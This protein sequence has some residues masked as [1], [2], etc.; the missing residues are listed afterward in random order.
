M[1][2]QSLNHLFVSLTEEKS[3]SQAHRA[4]YVVDELDY[5][6]RQTYE[7]LI[8]ATDS[9]SG[10]S[11]EV[12]VSVLV[13][14]V[15]DC[16]PEIEQDSY[17][18]TVS[19]R[20]P[21]GTAI[22][23]VQAKD[24]D[25]G[26][27]QV[28]NYALQTDSKNTSEHFHMDPADGVI[29]LK[30]SLDHET[31]S[32]HHF[33][34]VASDKGVPSLSSTAHVWVSVM[35]MNDNPPKFEQPSYSCVLSEHASRGQFVTVVSASDPDYIDH[36]RL[37]YTIAQGNELQTYG[38]DPV[39]GIITL[40]NM[41]NF[42]EKHVSILNV[43]VTDGVYT[44]F[45][46]VKITILPANLHNPVFEHMFYDAKVDENQLAGR[47]VTT[48]KA[49]DKDFGE[50]GRLAYSI[51]SDD[52]QDYFSIDKEKG[53]IV[54]K[55]KLDREERMHYDI[56]VMAVDAGGRAGF[57]TVRLRVGDENDNQPVF[58]YREYKTLIQGNLT[59]N[60]TFYRV[61]AV[62]ADDNQN[63]VVKYS[64]FDS[65]NSG[66]RELFGV[67]EN[68]GGLYLQ[69]SAVQWENQ[70]FQF[71]I[72]AHD[73]GTP[74]LYS[75]VPIDIYIMSSAENPPLFEKK[76]RKLFLSESSLPGTV[77]TRLKLSGNVTARYRILS[78]ELEEP[79]F[80]I[81]D[82]GQLRLAKTL[83]REVRDAHLIAIL[84]ET[85]S[86]P[87]LTAVTEIVLHVQDENDNTPIFESNPYS[88][89]LAENIEKGS[90]IMKLTARDA[91]SGSN[92]DI[93]YAL[94]PD[95]GD[96]VN[97]F[98]VDAYTGWITTLVALDKEKRED[99]KFQV[100]ATD[101]G[102]PKHTTRSTV[103]VRL[104][105]YND[106][107]PV[108]REGQYKASVSEDALPGTVVLQIATTD[109]DVE[110]RTAVEYYIIAG[111]SLSQF[112]IKNSGEVFVVKALDRESIAEYELKVIVTDGKYTAT[113]NI[114][115][116]VLDAN[117]NPPYCLKY[118]YREQLSEGARPG[119]HVL[120]VLAND[121]DEPANSRLRFYLTGNGAEDFNLDKDTGHLKTARKLD[122]ETQSRYSLM[123][124]VQD[125]D[126]PGWECSSQIELAL[127]DLN[128]NAPEFSMNPYSVTLPEDAEVGTL[129]TKIHATDADIGIN[130]KIKYAFLDSYRDH[131]RIAPESG[132][133]TLA[134]PLDRELKALYNLSVSATDLGHPALSNAATLIVN[135]QDIN[136]NPP[137]FT[138]KHYFA[139]VPEINAIGSEILKVLATS[140][141]TGI[142]A[143]I[144]Y[145]IIGGN[146]HRKFGIHNRTGVLSLADTLDYERAKDYFLTIQAVDGGTPPLSNLATVNISVTDSNDNHPQFTQNSY[147]ARIR[148]D[149]QRGDRILQVRANDLDAEENGRVS[150]TIE[151]GDRME[152]F[153]I[154]E[155]TGYV[156]VAGTLDRES[157]SNY[158][159]EV[160]ARDHG[161]PTLTAYVLVNIEISDANDNPP[162]FTQQNYTAVVQ[163]DKQIGH[164]L[165]KFDVTD[166]DTAP[167]AAPYTFDFRSG[168]EGGAFRIEQDG[169]LRTA[170]RFNSKIRDSYQ[171]QV[172]VFDN[173][174]PPLYSDTWVLVKVI[175]ESQYP[176]VITPLDIAIN[177]FLDEYPG[178]VIGKVYAT[179]QDQY[180]TLTY[181]L[182][183]TVGVL[184]SPTNLFN[185][186]RNDGVIYAY[187]RLD[188]GEYRVNVTVTDGKF[189]AYT[190]VKV[191]VEL[192]NE[193]MLANAIVIR[194]LKVSPEAFVLSHRKG[195]IRSVRNAIGCK[196]KD[197]IIISVQPSNDDDLNL[198][199]HRARRELSNGTVRARR[200]ANRDLDVLFTVRNG[201]TGGF[202]A[203]HEIRR[204]IDE[205]LEEI[206]D[207]TKLQIDEVVK[208]KCLPHYCIHGE[209]EDRIVLDAKLIHPVSTDVTSF[210]S[211]RHAHRMECACREGYGGDKCQHAV[212]ECSKAPC[213]P[214]KTCVPDSSDQGYHCTCREGFAGPKCDR[215]ITLCNDETCYVPRNPVSFSGKSYAHYRIEKEIARKNLED[216]LVLGLRLRTV[217]PTGNIMYSA[218]K[219]DFNVLEIMNGM[220]QYRFDL[221]SGEGLVS[222]SS[223]FV[224]DGLWHEVRLE[225]EG[226][227]AKLFVDGKH[228]AQGNAPGVNGVLNLQS[229][230][231]F[232]GA[233]VKQHPTVLGFQDVQR[234]FVGC[235]D[236]IRLSKIPVPLHMKGASSVASLRQFANVEFSCDAA[237]V[238]VPLGV[239]GTQ[240]CWNGGTCKDIGGGNFE[241]LCHSRFKGPYCK[242]DQNPC[243]SSPCLYGGKC[244]KVGFGNYTCDCPARMSGKRCDYGRFC[245]P[246]PCRNGGV[247]EEGDDGPLCMCHGYSGTFCETDID[248]CERQP[249]GS[250][251]TCINEAGSFRCICPPEMTGAS[252][253]D[254][255]SSNALTIAFKKVSSDLFFLAV[256]IVGLALVSVVVWGVTCACRK[257][258]R[259][260]R[261]EKINNEANKGIVLNPVS[262]ASG[263]KRGSKMSNLEIQRDQRP[264]SY[265]P[266]SNNAADHLYN[267]NAMLQYNNLDTLRS[268]GSAGDELEN[269][270]PEY[271]KGTVPCTQ[272]MV[273]N[274]NSGGGGGGNANTSDT[275]SLHKQKWTEQIQLQTFTD[276]INND[277]KRRGQ[278]GSPDPLLQQQQQQQH[279]QQ[280]QQQQPPHPST[281]HLRVS[282][283][284]LKP[285]QM[286]ILPGR[287]L[288]TQHSPTM[289][290]PPHSFEDGPAHHGSTAAYHW[291][292]S[293]W[294]GRGHHPLPNI[295]EVPGSEVP[296]SSSFH[297]NES[298]ESHPKASLLPPILGPVDSTRD[299]ETLNE[300]NESEYVDD[301][302][303]DQSEQPLSL[304]F[305]Q[306]S[307]ISCL[308]P[309]D[310]GSEDYRFN[311]ADSYLRHPNSYLPKYNIQSET[312]GENVPLT[313]RKPLNGLEIGR[314]QLVESDDDDVESYG[315]P[316]TRRNRREPSDIDL[317]LKTGKSRPPIG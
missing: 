171:L 178:G 211:A 279:Q 214:Y 246:N 186:S 84:A 287:L 148:E 252:C 242:E 57:S 3:F 98:D 13:Q 263:Y 160:Q 80:S 100:L 240:P 306:N 143:E 76:D 8:R 174:T 21:F 49:T 31:L 162:V 227:S 146:E 149:A 194:F 180:D 141:D 52:M 38:I 2:V 119:T 179:D 216:Q 304:G 5:E 94:S 187:P 310:S 62:D 278:G 165:L 157:I 22:L 23:K 36:D 221:G 243:A 234:G 150:Y 164:T 24:N 256:G 235:M 311:T 316:Q 161:V 295:T 229:D 284:Q 176:P 298:N 303:C 25:T 170:T 297:S 145:S 15:N 296:D 272:Q 313:G 14:D 1:S 199:Q 275:E 265:T 203:G 277:L 7:L 236:D 198:I 135:V 12:P 129:V 230:D 9:V 120:Q 153:A 172:R 104:K 33:T 173:G 65:Q 128:D 68:T 70:L 158:V 152:Q 219:V 210:V 136:D 142:N 188:V 183:P 63:A 266:S 42:A 175:E 101:N 144:T 251:A 125:R 253:G 102:Q 138:S 220:I 168:N 273:V 197:I 89:A 315:F 213:P 43:S 217:Q 166:A 20:A 233:E 215:D 115:V 307:S 117:D 127:T 255:L 78:D 122:R 55:K 282:P 123:A 140:K 250:G 58:Q 238:L 16:P 48:V 45:T 167:N 26:I 274:L 69:K 232:F 56:P 226:N 29:Y 30:K 37:V 185:I 222:V 93:R 51:I 124:H 201:Q 269:V 248:E 169:I 276:K 190:I 41:Q 289:L 134:K 312:E 192:I 86:S 82:A 28:I 196:I 105:D 99:Y 137:E 177:S 116:T 267:C 67:D 283:M 285:A 261:H 231:I 212:N 264:V 202:Y 81:N 257:K 132:I 193:E 309:L 111:D 108:F 223:I 109:R 53:E 300:D 126:H 156:A 139:S 95:V 239:C 260:S 44:S 288:N 286:G 195:F 97:I 191:S 317:V 39:S 71:F 83:D 151:R 200:N 40:V 159:L 271:R 208:S 305:E 121:M 308:N 77:I 218:G 290:M 244:S 237:S 292:C 75:D 61:R 181:G 259:S 189:A 147:S 19:E 131:F 254:P 72:R 262:E 302:E 205:N 209:C 314:H 85:D 32:H 10:V 301:S 118:R 204:V 247:C 228:V 270:P 113:A 225:R 258:R 27:N 107:P 114:S 291:D 60:T 87:P 281:T 35:D 54:T 112:Q 64:I 96:I 206:E 294:V 133:V 74:S 6:R 293:D 245:T 249:C 88:F 46:R 17:N 92:G 103:I 106:C 280:Q 268:Y 47:L 90:S 110:L 207:A 73:G 299:I 4:I 91:D 163:E 224:S 79:Q 11:A 184:Y 59:V 34:V 66:I 241:C 182:A 50:Y 18:I 155:D 154:E 130:R